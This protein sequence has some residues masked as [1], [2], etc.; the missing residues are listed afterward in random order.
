MFVKFYIKIKELF[1]V[2]NKKMKE[3]K[4]NSNPLKYHTLRKNKLFSI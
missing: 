2:P 4:E 3:K 1:N